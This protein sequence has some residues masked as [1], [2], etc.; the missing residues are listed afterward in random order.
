MKLVFDISVLGSGMLDPKARTGVFRVV[1]NLARALVS[2]GECDVRFCA[3]GDTFHPLYG[4]MRYLSLAPEFRST[5]FLSATPRARAC[6]RALERLTT[7]QPAGNGDSSTG[8]LARVRRGI[9]G[10]ATTF[11]A[12]RPFPVPPSVARG[13]DVYHSPYA[14]LPRWPE[15]SARTRFLM[16]HDLIAVRWPHFYEPHVEANDRAILESIGADDFVTCNSA[17]TRDDLCEFTGLDPAR[18]FVTPLAASRELF[19]PVTDAARRRDV[20][21]RHGVPDAPYLLA[22]GTLK[23]GKNFVTTIRS[24]ARLVESERLDDL[25]LVLVG[26]RG[27]D[28]GA[29]FEAVEEAGPLRDRIHFTGFVADEDLAPLYSGALAFVF[30]SMYEGFG[31]PVL[32]AMQCGVPVVASNRSSIPEV[33]G[34]AGILVDPTDVDGY[35]EALLSLY[36]DSGRRTELA[37]AAVG[38]ASEFSWERCAAETIAAYRVALGS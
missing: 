28:Y 33:V 22:L 17:S 18:A 31:L 14:P 13:A 1:E 11:V 5:P 25:R 12:G 23:P 32:E 35:C 26:T 24:F 37:R 10:R 29:V 6:S 15:R 34:D 9:R 36:R 3:G 8:F 38:R 19:H 2:S 21:E 7:P 20:L 30:P 4:T 27:W 16:I